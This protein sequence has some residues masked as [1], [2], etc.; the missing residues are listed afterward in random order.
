MWLLQGQGPRCN[1]GI[2][3]FLP[4]Q[5]L[6]DRQQQEADASRRQCTSP[7]WLQVI[8][9]PKPKAEHWPKA[10]GGSRRQGGGDDEESEGSGSEGEGDELVADEGAGPNVEPTKKSGGH[11]SAGHRTGEQG[12]WGH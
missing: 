3:L 5:P 4:Q 12:R 6:W 8:R 1:T 10:A 2:K 7:F 11:M 9:L